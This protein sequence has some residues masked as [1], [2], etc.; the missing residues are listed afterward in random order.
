[1]ASAEMKAVL[2]FVMTGQRRVHT[3][4]L[5]WRAEIDETL[6]G[7]ITDGAQEHELSLGGR[8]ALHLR[9]VTGESK[10]VVLFLHGGAYQVGSITAYRAFA[11]SLAL[12]LQATVV[13]LDYRLAPEHPF[14]AAINDALAAYAELVESVGRSRLA[15]I[16]DS[17]G[18][19]LT[20]ALL[21]AARRA[22]M[23]QPVAAACLSP[24]TDLTMT[25]DSYTRCA[26][27]DPF[28]D[29]NS[30]KSCAVAYLAGADPQDPLAS[31]VFATP[32]EL[33]SLAPLLIQA[34]AGEVLADDAEALGEAIQASGGQVQL[35]LWPDAFHVWH[36]LGAAV[37]E[38]R[39]ATA[40]LVRF[41]T[42]RWP[43]KRV[44]P[45]VEHRGFRRQADS[46]S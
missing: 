46:T 6:G 29:R 5:E 10:G 15:V 25:A 27:S 18:G 34:A 37:P 35:E 19:G 21:I 42:A 28:L 30:L 16:G 1:M 45:S 17:A 44:P 2:K 8:P 41:I 24:W 43:D 31:P 23:P 32:G 11:S 38:A 40:E 20:V 36:M 9:P 33:S 3:S 14:P 26:E 39:D 12:H 4:V 13:L 22:R 7:P